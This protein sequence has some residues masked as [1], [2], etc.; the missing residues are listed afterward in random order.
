M[1]QL[2]RETT[3]T[4]FSTQGT[5]I[6]PGPIGRLARLGWG[7]F[8]L[9]GAFQVVAGW[10]VLVSLDSLP[11]WSFLLI[12]A[13]V[14]WRVFPYVVTIGLGLNAR[15]APLAFGLLAANALGVGLSLWGTGNLWSPPMGWFVG[16]WFVYTLLHLGVSFLLASAVATPGCEMRAIPHLWS[17]L[18]GQP[19]REHFCPGH[20]DRVDR[21]ENK[22]T[23]DRQ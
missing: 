6:A 5:L 2:D 15:Y 4:Q 19:A 12:A 20:L 17:M 8:V 13:F 3:R 11:H 16:V 9:W 23:E 14:A 7:I 1:S 21:W 22:L 10:Q 18:R